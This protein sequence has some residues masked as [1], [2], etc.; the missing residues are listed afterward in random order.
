MSHIN[1]TNGKYLNDY[2]KSKLN[3]EFIPFNEAMIQGKLLYPL[4]DD[5]FNESRCKTHKVTKLEYLE[6]IKDFLNIK[7]YS[8]NIKSITLWFGQDAFCIIN[9]VTVLCY[10]EDIKYRGSVNLNIVDDETCH[11]LK[12]NIKLSLGH[13]KNVYLKLIDKE[14]TLV[15]EDFINEGLNDYLYIT[16]DN[17]FVIDYIKENIK[18]FDIETLVINILKNTT[19]YGLSDVFIKKLITKIK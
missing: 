7:E 11:V 17:N 3:G 12:E 19:K 10:L 16:S 9:L 13:F 4:F 6:N 1:I 5:K 14:L 2:L 18:V 15:K 8:S